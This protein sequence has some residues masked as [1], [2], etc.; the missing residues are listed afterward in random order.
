[1]WKDSLLDFQA[2]RQLPWV[3]QSALLSYATVTNN[4]PNLRD[5]QQQRFLSASCYVVSA[6]CC[7]SA[8][9]VLFILGPG[10]KELPP[11]RT[12]FSMAEGK[13]QWQDHR[14][15][16]QVFSKSN[17][18]LPLSLHS[19]KQVTWPLQ[20]GAVSDQES[21]RAGAF[22]SP[23][24]T[25]PI[26]HLGTHAWFLAFQEQD[27]ERLRSCGHSSIFFTSTLIP[28]SAMPDALILESLSRDDASCL[29]QG[30]RVG[31]VETG[32]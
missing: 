28:A 4:P 18:A 10:L 26:S 27:R 31:W 11:S 15:T 30:G 25:P 32:K 19:P 22:G 7:S 17:T 16:L 8:P 9:C 5:T 2:S 14:M 23:Q 1:M 24:K 3:H 21:S 29:L 20:Q 13:E 6:G 12:R